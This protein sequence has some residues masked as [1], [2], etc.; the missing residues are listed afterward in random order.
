MA[1]RRMIDKKISISEQVSNLKIEAQLI[2][3]WSIP[4]ADDFGL[5]PFSHK[6]LKA[7]IV[8]MIEMDLETF[9][10]HLEAIVSE[11][12]FEVF[13]DKNNK[14]KK[15]YKIIKF[16]KNQTLKK[17]R[18][19]NVLLENITSWDELEDI[20]FH[21]ED[22][23]NPSKDK[24]SKVKR[25]EVKKSYAE[26]NKILTDLLY[27]LVKENYPFLKEEDYSKDYKEMDK[28]H[29]IDKWNYEQIEY[30]IRWSQQDDFWKQNIRSVSKLR[31]Q[32]GNLAVR[33]KENEKKGLT[34]I[35][36]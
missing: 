22:I 28:L 1:Q 35:K 16:S 30:I 32:F 13:E 34:V 7:M 4:H 25:R 5:L 11:N 27:K 36:T 24:L 26:K 15:Y 20:G 21:L 2:F 12:L 14:N 9:V 18:K 19:P 33:A 6:T 10:F 3:T 17:D 31:K 29:R 8:P 23:G